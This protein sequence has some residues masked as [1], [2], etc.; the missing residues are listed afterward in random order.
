MRSGLGDGNGAS[1]KMPDLPVARRR[2]AARAAAFAIDEGA[3]HQ[4]C[5]AATLFLALF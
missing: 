4:L 3:N 2:V 5:V 1:V